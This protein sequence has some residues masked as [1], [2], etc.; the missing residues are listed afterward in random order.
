VGAPQRLAIVIVFVNDRWEKGTTIML[1]IA[2]KEICQQLEDGLHIDELDTPTMEEL[3]KW[4]ACSE[5]GYIKLNFEYAATLKD[6]S[7]KCVMYKRVEAGVWVTSVEDAATDDAL[8]V[9]SGG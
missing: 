6:G 5:E 4:A 3:L 9:P 1:V 7:G 8:E 2:S